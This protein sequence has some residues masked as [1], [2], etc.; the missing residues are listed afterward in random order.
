MR[1]GEPRDRWTCLLLAT[2][3]RGG[4][5]EVA[6]DAR[7]MT[8]MLF[9]FRR[10][11]APRGLQRVGAGYPA[12]A[13]AWRG[14]RT[15][16][17]GDLRCAPPTTPSARSATCSRSTTSA[18]ARLPRRRR[19]SSSRS[20]STTA[21][22]EG[23]HLQPVATVAADNSFTPYI[24]VHEFGHHFA[25]LADEYYTSDVAYQSGAE[26]LEAVGAERPRIAG[27]QVEGTDRAGHS[28]AHAVAQR[29]FEKSQREVQA[30]GAD[31]RRASAGEE[32]EALFREERREE[33][34]LLGG[35]RAG[36][37]VRGRHVR[38]PRLLPAAARLHHVHAR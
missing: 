21:S 32:M 17:G 24:F 14:R 37:S 31:P 25:G 15:V 5:G 3:T 9:A 2:A 19:T 1:N 13:S 4:D 22:T 18:C 34:A 10:S 36:G 35:D 20:W 27:L 38:G 26:R 28:A 7:R 29:G 30:R 16:C 33:T 12:A 11:R 23:R 6:P 8:E